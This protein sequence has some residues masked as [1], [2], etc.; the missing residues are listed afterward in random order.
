MENQQKEHHLE[1]GFS[2]SSVGQDRQLDRQISHFFSENEDFLHCITGMCVC[3]DAR[4]TSLS[5]IAAARKFSI[6]P[7][8]VATASLFER[9]FTYPA[10]I[11]LTLKG[12]LL[13]LDCW[14]HCVKIYSCH[15][16][17]YPTPLKDEKYPFLLSPNRVSFP[18]LCGWWCCRVNVSCVLMV[19]LESYMF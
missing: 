3:V 2:I 17:R 8:A 14:D 16:R 18:F 11:A 1:G 5:L 19:A 9:T 13:V 7:R 6:F 10:G 15:L 4:V 12:Q